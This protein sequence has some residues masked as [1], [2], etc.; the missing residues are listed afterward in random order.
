[1]A[2]CAEHERKMVIISPLAY[3]WPDKSCQVERD[4][5]VM[6]LQ[7]KLDKV[8]HLRFNPKSCHLNHCV[9]S[10]HGATYPQPTPS[11]AP[12]HSFT[13]FASLWPGPHYK[14]TRGAFS[15]LRS[16]YNTAATHNGWY[17]YTIIP[18]HDVSLFQCHLFPSPLIATLF[19]VPSSF[20]LYCCQCL[21]SQLTAAANYYTPSTNACPTYPSSPHEQ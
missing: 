19:T 16:P 8:K 10:A 14:F 1:M 15:S 21:P 9:A 18:G 17:R 7:K 12:S 5:E 6:L 3:T 11:T 2:F 4:N 13:P 20:T